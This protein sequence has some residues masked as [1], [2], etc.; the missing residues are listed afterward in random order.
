MLLQNYANNMD[1]FSLKIVLKL[2]LP[3][4][5]VK[6]WAQLVMLEHLVLPGKNLG[7]YG[8]AGAIVTQN[9]KL[10]DKMRMFANHGALKKHFHDIEGINSRMDGLQAAV[11]SVKLKHITSWSEARYLNALKYHDYLQNITSIIVPKIRQNAKH[12][13]H[14]YVI[15]THNRSLVQEKLKEASISSA[16]HYPTPLPYLNAY[17]Y[18]NHVPS[19]FPVSYDYKNKYCLYLCMQN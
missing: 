4:G 14:L 9:D 13:F 5:M 3:N 15:R 2:T 18:L 12:V 17:K 16:V 19:D 7:A 6:K 11:L 10:A 8:D 1:Y